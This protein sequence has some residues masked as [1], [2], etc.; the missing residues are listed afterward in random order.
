MA[1]VK[2]D[3]FT[4]DER[5][6]LG[7]WAR[8]AWLTIKEREQAAGKV[9]SEQDLAPW[10]MLCDADKEVFRKSG[11]DMS[12]GATCREQLMWA[13]LERQ[14]ALMGEK[15]FREKMY[16]LCVGIAL[17]R[18]APGVPEHERE[19]ATDVIV[20]MAGML[21]VPKDSTSSG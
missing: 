13:E 16:S 8:R 18:I 20:K 12:G 19:K 6:C 10:D 2:K 14:R 21:E 4:A 11:E 15:A 1:K 5:E 9:V 17:E 7:K 3:K